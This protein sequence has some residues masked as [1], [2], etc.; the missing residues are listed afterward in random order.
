MSVIQQHDIIQEDWANLSEQLASRPSRRH[1]WIRFFMPDLAISLA[2]ITLIY[3]LLVFHAP[4]MLFRD[5][6]TGWHLRTG[7]RILTTGTLPQTDPYSFSKAGAPW[8]AGDWAS[9]VA[10]ASVWKIAGL[11]GVAWLFLIA[12]A[13]CTFLWV[14]LNWAAG[15]NLF[16]TCLLAAPMLSTVSLRFLALPHVFGW[17]LL[18]GF[19]LYF[20]GASPRF[21]I[22]EAVVTG[23]GSVLWANVDGSF[24]MLPVV[25]VAYAIGHIVR[26][27]VWQVD[28]ALEWQRARWFLFAAATALGASVFNPC[29][30]ALHVHVLRYLTDVGLL[31]RIRELENFRFDAGGSWQILLT[32]GVATSG[33]V[34]A[35]QQKKVGHFILT[36]LFLAL[37]LK[38]A[39]TLPMATLILLPLANG[40]I[41]GALRRTRELR[42]G[43][44]HG[45]LHFLQYSD[46]LRLLDERFSGLVWTP[47]VALLVFG[48]L[49]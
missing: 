24:L 4:Q 25:A 36:V 21:G 45:L 46:R 35:L 6:G 48:W 23:L 16:I 49:R 29:G 18:I 28:T 12:L 3:C 7:E 5:S 39:R 13:A 42:P 14:R 22:R 2:G 1:H 44:R 41:T 26:L 34:L 8:L 19:V 11:S 43:L 27:L 30:V 17:I 33:G 37:A 31:D 10:M 38:S 9:D 15:G 20:E 32:A 47:F 40:A